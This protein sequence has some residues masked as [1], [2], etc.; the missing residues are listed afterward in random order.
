VITFAA[1]RKDDLPLVC[2]WLER[3]HVR[4][5]WNDP[6]E[7][8]LADYERAIDGLDPTEHYLIVL[9]GRPVGMI[10]ACIATAE[11]ANRRWWRAFE[12]AGFEHVR[13]VEERRVPHRLMRLERPA[14]GA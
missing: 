11:D 14:R 5:W 4:R 7:Q 3:E 10:E 12:I 9:D 1:L 2:E 8:E 6:I 13:D